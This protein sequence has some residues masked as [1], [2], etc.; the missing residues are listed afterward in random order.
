MAVVER[1]V[2][3]LRLRASGADD[4]RRVMPV[5]EDALRCASLPDVGHRVL[6]VRKLALG[7]VRHD[8]NAQA[9]ALVIEQR[10]A[11]VQATVQSG[12]AAGGSAAAAAAD[13]VCFD[14]ALQA[15]T[16]LALA[17]SRG[18]DVGAWY[19]PLAVPEWRGTQ[20]TAD[21]LRRMAQH[22]ATWPEARTALPAWAAALLQAGAAALLASAFDEAEGRALLQRVG[23]ALEQPAVGRAGSV[24]Q[25][26]VAAQ[27]A[28][29]HTD[30]EGRATAPADAR[31]PET[32]DW[33]LRLWR[34]ATGAGAARRWNRLPP[35][36]PTGDTPK[37]QSRSDAALTRPAEHATAPT[38][39]SL[40]SGRSAESTSGRLQKPPRSARLE[41]PAADPPRPGRHAFDAQA[42]PAPP[43]DGERAREPALEPAFLPIHRPA[44][45]PTACAGLLFL[46]PILQHL[47]LPDWLD[48]SPD[49]D[50]ACRV[51]Q[52]ALLRLQ[53]PADDAIWT[54][55]RPPG[56]DSDEQA[57]SHPAPGSW[58]EPLLA[59]PRGGPTPALTPAAAL[60]ACTT[61]NRQA[62]VWLDMARRWL[63]RA[64]R[65]G[66]ARLVL[67]PG[68][69]SL[70]ATHV[71][72]IFDLNATD[73]RVRRLGLDL[74]PGWLPRFGRVVHYHYERPA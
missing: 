44:D 23:L 39:P 55:V 9:L 56:P 14:G 41:A 64:G 18:Q 58:A 43:A 36:E 30:S 59:A 15:R 25:G 3:Q 20:G 22:I 46:L 49:G 5:L 54:L 1:R 29:L 50:F 66:L 24:A 73:I 31:P 57:S 33:L 62:Q 2:R 72:L 70:T 32:P 35:N 6:L 71:D 53:A 27:R 12:W 16:E 48:E 61:A 37:L 8:L 68:S 19:W 65:F 69:L 63:R 7:R 52:A 34:A 21:A 28:R 60:A 67:R 26:T 47:G 10:L 4:V 42:Q 40:D 45:A 13:R 51:L 11:Q 74:D 17:L 38:P